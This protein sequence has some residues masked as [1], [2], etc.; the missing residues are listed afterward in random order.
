M[1]QLPPEYLDPNTP[2][3][4]VV[5]DRRR[6]PFTDPTLGIAVGPAAGPEPAHALVT[7]GD[8]LT[9][10]MISGAVHQ[11]E[12][13]WPAL[14]ARSL[15][16]PFEVPGYG[17]P[18]GGLPFNIEGLLRALEDRYGTHINPLEALGLPVAL[19]SLADEN[20]DWWERGPGSAPP[21]T[22]V[23]YE[24]V[25]IYGW[26]LRDCLSYTAGRATTR[27][28]ANPS[29]DDLLGAIP[30]NDTDIAARSVLAP[31]GMAAA[32]VS[33][34]AWHGRNGGIGTLVVVL[35]SNNALR[36][37]VDKK[38][39]WSDSGFDDL[40]RKG[41]FNV[42]RPSHFAV[43]FGRLVTALEQI[44]ARRVVLA[45]VPHVT[46]APIAK[47]VNPQDHG[48][49][50]RPGSRYFPYYTDFWIEEADFRPDKHRHLTHQQA[51]AI[52]S[53]IDQ[54]NDTIA[55]VVADARRDGRPWFLLDL[56][57]ILDG[58]A[59]RR[60]RQDD[61]AAARN[62]WQAYELPAPIADLTT[63]FFRSD[64]SGKRTQGGLFG[65]DGVHP[66]TCGYGV[67]AAEVLAILTADGL[68][69]KPL[70]FAELRRQDTLNDRP[71][72]LLDQVFD[73]ASPFLTRLVSRSRSECR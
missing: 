64:A 59:A 30:S 71:P 26:D 43:E 9:H 61:E 62:D 28:A 24:N 66:T 22:D 72:R 35:G 25:G 14:V 42:W 41:R 52:D 6:Q 46:I 58:L 16:V 54:Y 21:R 15:G 12:L 36:T 55:G 60:F 39:C 29:H 27:L 69:A 57:G 2:A 5:S 70:D 51:R 7:V 3:D 8:S 17:G 63:R 23:R 49:K 4:V 48:Q 1:P 68:T 56:C 31:F 11:T 40:D 18:L 73:L 32:Q 53:A 47:G 13:S 20:E 65:L 19:H 45:T 44:D 37:V 38:V 50:W 10:G 67:I 33:A 34:A